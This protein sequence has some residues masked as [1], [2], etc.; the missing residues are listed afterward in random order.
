MARLVPA[1][2]A[3]L[4]PVSLTSMLARA[5]PNCQIES[6]SKTRIGIDYGLASTNF[7]CEIEGQ[8]APTSLVA[9][10]WDTEGVG[11]TS[12]VNFYDHV[13]SKLSSS[14]PCCYYGAIDKEQHR[15][16]LLLEDIANARQG[17]CTERASFEETARLTIT[18]AEIHAAHWRDSNLNSWVWLPDFRPLNA[19]PEWLEPRAEKIQQL[20][21]ELFDPLS[22]NL[23][24]IA[25][26]VAARAN[27]LLAGG[28]Q[29]LV[30][31]DL[32]LDNVIFDDL[33][34][35]LYLLD[36][37][38]AVKGSPA[39]DLQ[40]LLF[41]IG[42]LDHFNQLFEIY[43]VNVRELGAELEEAQLIQKLEGGLLRNFIRQT[44][45]L[46]NWPNPHGRSLEIIKTSIERAILAVNFWHEQNPAL[47]S[48]G[49]KY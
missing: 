5:F 35:R 41:D 2:E 49:G 46:A 15:G 16:V 19:T 31:G 1:T 30:H 14:I 42:P 32:H 24:A 8:N 33:N 12:E 3:D 40:V 7:R 23:L 21:G 6:L 26:K 38:S 37:A 4:T 34:C 25:P 29:T 45:G 13:G 28:Y 10:L 11:G 36:W 17:D 48:F 20:Y 43:V 27:A 18:L 22:R 44:C 39:L 9:K 47:F